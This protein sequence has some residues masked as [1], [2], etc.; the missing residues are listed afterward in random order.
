MDIAALSMGLSQAELADQ[1]G[2]RVLAN[3]L[4]LAK[5]R[6][7]DMVALIS[8]ATVPPLEEGSGGLVDSYV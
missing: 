2:T 3:S 7:E 4:D 8:S 1:V 6:G 5:D